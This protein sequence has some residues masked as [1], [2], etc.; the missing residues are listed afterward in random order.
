MPERTPKSRS[1]RRPHQDA[2]V[3]AVISGNLKLV[4]QMHQ[5]GALVAAAYR[6]GWLPIHRAA[7]NDRDKIIQLLI[8]SGSPIEAKGTEGWT[9]L[10]LAAVS[11][12]TRAVAALVS[13]GADVNAK[14]DFGK[15][16]FH[17]AIGPTINEPMLETARILVAA[18]ATTDPSSTEGKTPLDEAEELASQTSRLLSILKNAKSA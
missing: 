14:S 17:L 16:P 2:F 15:T 5:A 13:A 18:G 12:S 6:F 1:P 9:P 10:H 4:R 11:K 7:S 3:Q 8:K